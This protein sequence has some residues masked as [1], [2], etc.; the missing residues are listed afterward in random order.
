MINN[1]F[2]YNTMRS[3]PEQMYLF[4]LSNTGMNIVQVSG[5]ATVTVTKEGI[6]II[7]VMQ[8]EEALNFMFGGVK[9]E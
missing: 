8:P 7:R 5:D 6:N 2:D 1:S 9:N 3:P 4:L